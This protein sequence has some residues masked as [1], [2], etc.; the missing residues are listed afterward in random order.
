M[1]A[2]DAPLGSSGADDAP[3]GE[4]TALSRRA[5]I[6]GLGAAGALGLA[7]TLGG[8]THVAASGDV[9]EAIDPPIEGLTYL[10]LD[11]LAFDVAAQTNAV[12]RAYDDALGM[13]PSVY[14][15]WL[16]ASLPIP[17]GSVVRKIRIW[18]VG[19]PVVSIGQRL[20]GNATG[21]ADLTPLTTLTAG[22]AIKTQ[23]LDVDA[24]I[25]G[26]TTYVI[27]AFCSTGANLLGMEIGYIPPAQVLIPYTGADPR[28]FD[29]RLTTRFGPDEERV[30]D[31]SAALIPTARAAVINLTATDTGG[32]GFLAAFRDGIE[33]PGNSSVN[34]SAAGATVANG[35]VVPMADGKIKVRT[36]PAASHVIVDVIG[37]LL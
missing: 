2:H 36:G 35:A 9:R 15:A 10:T 29:S 4:A 3:A 25:V 18:F 20:R 26:G 6:G 24:E 19:Q 13:R 8:A 34:F 33:Y 28:V 1:T 23:T 21:F 32:P 16:Y 37:S 5:L 14:P 11:A 12:H 17:V 30:I 27:R 7:G 31:L 22:A